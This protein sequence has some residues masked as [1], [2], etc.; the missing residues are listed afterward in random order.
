MQNYIKQNLYL[1]VSFKKEE[2]VKISVP[3]Y[4]RIKIEPEH[5]S[6]EQAGKIFDQSGF[7]Y[8]YM[9]LHLGSFE[10]ADI[11]K[12]MKENVLRLM[13]RKDDE[14]EPIWLPKQLL[15]FKDL[16]LEAINYH[17]QYYEINKNAFIYLTVRSC[18]YDELFY[19]NSFS[20]HIDGF[21]GSKIKRH[22]IEQ[23]IFWCNKSP[24]QFLLQPFFCEGLNPSKHDINDFFD[25]QAN[26]KFLINTFKNSLYCVNPYQVHR[27]NPKK[28][29]GQRVF[30]RINFSPVVI[31]DPTNSLNPVLNDN[32]IQEHRDVRDFL[33]GY[34]IN[35]QKG[36]G[37]KF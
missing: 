5:P 18:T 31:E 17:R 6:Y 3:H 33:R 34:C 15:I 10:I 36:S 12:K 30:V 1:P 24:T 32:L 16:I 35:E 21:Q 9:P 22:I 19:K 2:M 20:W 23:N 7:K 27:V 14:N 28:Y 8:P 26:D 4:R 37:F 25:K 29:K 13:V 11:E